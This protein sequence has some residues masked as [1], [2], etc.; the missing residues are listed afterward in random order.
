M[1]KK[2]RVFTAFL[3]YDSQCLA[4]DRLK[5]NY[6][7]FD[8]ELVGWAEIDKYAIQAHNAIYPQWADRNYGDISKINWDDVPDF[9]LFT[10]SSPCQDFSNA[11]KQAGGEEG[12]GTRSSL[13]WECRRVIIA[14]RPKFL[15]MENVSAL[16]SQKFLPT[17]NKWQEELGGYG[18]TNF[19]Q[20]LN[21]KHYGVPQNRER[22]FLVSILGDA[23]YNFPHPVKLTKRLKD[24]LEPVVDE[25]YYLSEKT[26]TGFAKHNASHEAKGTGFKFQPKTK[27]DIAVCIRANS[28]LCPTDNTI[29]EVRQ[30][31]ATRETGWNRQQYRVYGIDG[32]SPCLNSLSGGG[33]EPKIIDQ[34][35][36]RIPEA[37]AKGYTEAY[38]G[39]S[40]NLEQPNSKTRRGRVGKQMANTLTTS[41][42][43]GVVTP[44]YR[45]RKL[46]PRECFRLMDVD[47]NVIDK[48]QAAGIS[49]SQQ[50]KMA[51][52]SIV[53]ACL[54]GIFEQ[55][56]Y[57]KYTNS[58]TLF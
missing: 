37:T 36:Y 17:F 22:I 48:I 1:E 43:Q 9:D 41:N 50:Y 13:L 19:A 52:N 14:K 16:V 2:I 51:G 56:F 31:G 42:A 7:G 58:G 18:Y 53:V 44:N 8:Y 45:I 34:P 40:V 30:V 24:V 11:G 15:L 46:T 4:L 32:L 57:P 29:I 47:D 38:E 28:A 5:E 3:G 35:H 33:L 39:D 21:A 12:S 26:L 6:P 25:K 20:V 49:N 23:W 27:E 10:Y 55:L 54:Y